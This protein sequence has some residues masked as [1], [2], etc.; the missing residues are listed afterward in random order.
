MKQ[1]KTAQQD[2]LK[3]DGQLLM[4]EQ[5]RGMIESAHFNKQVF[6]GLEQGKKAVDAM[7][8]EMDVDKMEEL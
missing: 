4:L 8:K 6:T 7:Q 3:L 5:Q 2:I 1:V